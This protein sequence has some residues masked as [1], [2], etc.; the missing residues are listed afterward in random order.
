MKGIGQAPRWVLAT[1]ETSLRHAAVPKLC[2][3]CM[4]MLLYSW[5][6]NPTHGASLPENKPTWIWPSSSSSGR[7]DGAARPPAILLLELG[8]KRDK[9]KW[10]RHSACSLAPR[11]QPASAFN[12]HHVRREDI[13]PSTAF[14]AWPMSASY[15][16]IL[17]QKQPKT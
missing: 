3:R 12:G 16:L 13:Y 4:W 1:L 5:L 9:E 10:L 17:N 8:E 15:A 14:V 7:G 2:F 11:S 6:Q